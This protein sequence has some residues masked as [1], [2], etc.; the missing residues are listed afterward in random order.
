MSTSASTS[1]SLPC[2]CIS[3]SRPG[4][5]A[6]ST[7]RVSVKT[8]LPT[9]LASGHRCQ[10]ACTAGSQGWSVVL[11]LTAGDPGFQRELPP[12][13][14]SP[15]ARYIILDE[16]PCWL[17]CLWTFQPRTGC[18]L[19]SESSSIWI[20]AHPLVL[21]HVAKRKHWLSTIN[22]VHSPQVFGSKLWST[23]SSP[24][25]KSICHVTVH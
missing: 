2:G 18:G 9:P 5:Q 13:R 4:A 19:N 22:Y 14:S 23:S 17:G 8:I 20:S 21:S 25:L 3:T 12:G 24:S 7:R 6:P 1:G 10:V 16:S 11:L 15:R